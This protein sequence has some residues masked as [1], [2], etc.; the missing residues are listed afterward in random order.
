MSSDGDN[1]DVPR[2][3]YVHNES[4]FQAEITEILA[5]SDGIDDAI[6]TLFRNGYGKLLISRGLESHTDEEPAILKRRVIRV[7][8][9]MSSR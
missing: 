6:R 7:V 5:R 3:D 9:E 8:N 4:R 2:T 1:L